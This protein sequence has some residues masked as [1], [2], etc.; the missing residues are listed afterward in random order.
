MPNKSLKR[1]KGPL[2]GQKYRINSKYKTNSH[3]N[4]NSNVF[5]CYKK[6]AICLFLT[7]RLFYV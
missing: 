3:K 7:H 6:Q 2:L 5:L 4:C 1:L